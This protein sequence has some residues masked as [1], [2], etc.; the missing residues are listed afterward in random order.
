MGDWLP[1][2]AVPEL[3]ASYLNDSSSP[4][5]ESTDRVEEVED[6]PVLPKGI[7]QLPNT[8]ASSQAY[9]GNEPMPPNYTTQAIIGIVLGTMCC[10]P[11]I[12]P[13]IVAIVHGSKIESLY[14]V[15]DFEGAREAS[16]KAKYWWNIAVVA[17]V[18]VILIWVVLGIIGILTEE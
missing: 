2:S 15:G 11:V 4:D 17:L 12:A 14:N 8:P 10:T 18:V 16:A 3:V 1:V 7:P 13:A 9:A 6:A 5:A